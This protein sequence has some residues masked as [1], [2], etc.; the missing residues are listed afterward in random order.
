MH[1]KLI[2]I[3]GKKSNDIL[4]QPGSP[5][6]LTASVVAQW[7]AVVATRVFLPP[8]FPHRLFSQINSPVKNLYP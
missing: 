1:N 4:G 5:Q 6:V 7:V 8:P 2:K 3:G